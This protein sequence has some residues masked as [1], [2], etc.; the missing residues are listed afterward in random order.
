M[1]NFMRR[2][3]GYTSDVESW[4]LFDHLTWLAAVADSTIVVISADRIPCA[5]NRPN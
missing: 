1:T 5:A 3:L 4:Q 2:Q